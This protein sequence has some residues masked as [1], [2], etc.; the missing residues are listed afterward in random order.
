[1]IQLVQP[2]DDGSATSI[3]ETMDSRL[4]RNRSEQDPLGLTQGD[5]ELEEGECQASPHEAMDQDEVLGHNARLD[6]GSASET[7]MAFGQ[8]TDPQSEAMDVAGIGSESEGFSGRPMDAQD[9]RHSRDNFESSWDEGESEMAKRRR[10]YPKVRPY[11]VP[12][13]EN[14]SGWYQGEDLMDPNDVAPSARRTGL[15]NVDGSIAGDTRYALPPPRESRHPFY[16]DREL[17]R[18]VIYDRAAKNDKGHY[19]HITEEER[20]ARA[21]RQDTALQCYD[22]WENT[23]QLPR[24]ARSTIVTG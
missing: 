19:P 2:E 22:Y 9:A 24:T 13:Q 15:P 5:S 6:E 1:M 11:V 4:P 14:D 21:E 17:R 16:F 8:T 23:S 12:V 18:R 20:A 7:S 3:A 10:K